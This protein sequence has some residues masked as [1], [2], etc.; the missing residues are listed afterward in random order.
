MTK[1][2]MFV[3]AIILFFS[4]FHTTKTVDNNFRHELVTCKV[5]KDC[6]DQASK[7]VEFLKTHGRYLICDKGVCRLINLN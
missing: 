7:F 2:L 6:Y 3:F 4:R 1:T 5:D